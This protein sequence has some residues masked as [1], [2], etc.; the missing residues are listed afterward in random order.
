MRIGILLSTLGGSPLQGGIERGLAQLGHHVETFRPHHSYD[1]VCVFNQTAHATNYTYPQPPSSKVPIAFIDSAEFGVWSRLPDRVYNYAN[2]FS[3]GALD[4]DTKN[5][6]EQLKLKSFLEGKSFPYFIREFS[7][8]VTFPAA[9]H[10]IDYPLY[11]HSV[12]HD[13]PNR[14]EYLKREL[15][16]FVSWGASHPWRMQITQALRDCHTKCEI[17]VLEQDGAVRM[18]QQRF[19]QRTRAAKT[20]VSFDGY[21]SGSFRM[22]EVL[23]RCLLLQGPL[24][25]IRHAPL[26][27]GVHCVEYRVETKGEEF[28][29]TD[30][31][32][33]LR[34]SLADPESSYR[35]YEAGYHHCFTHYTEK[36]TAQ[37]V[38][39]TV[40]KHDWSKATE[41]DIKP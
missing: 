13:R 18:P 41:L 35:I 38:L 40:A 27:D 37:Y 22:T 14:E 36:A 6:N 24:S 30:V 11:H 17:S 10:P 20:S 39:D 8:H 25:I 16:L 26:I 9:Y 19:F 29:S 28:I 31:C 23:V 32:Q 2:T 21:G 12:C 3:P 4:H 33:V 15:E 1:L 7:K 5:K 34:R